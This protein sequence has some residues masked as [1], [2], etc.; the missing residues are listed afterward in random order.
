MG[1]LLQRYKLTFEICSNGQEAVSR[2]V[3]NGET[4]QMILM[5][6]EMPVMDGHEVCLRLL[7]IRLWTLF[8]LSADYVHQATQA[9]RKFDKS[10]PV[11]GLTGNALDEQRLEFLA[12][13]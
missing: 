11:V 12:C 4:F 8:D 1:R 10:V 2:V 5:D 3:E 7:L 6:K 13:G 9:I